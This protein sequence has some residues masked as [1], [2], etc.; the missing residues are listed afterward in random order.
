MRY[1]SFVRINPEFQSSVNLEFDLNRTDKIQGY[2]PTE[3]SVRILGEFLRTFYYNTES[4]GRATVLIGPYGRGKSHLLLVLSA[5]TSLD[6]FNS[7]SVDPDARRIQEELCSKIARVNSEVGALAKAV[8]DSSIRTLPVIINSNSIEINQAFLVA[9]SDSLRRAGLDHLLPETYFDSA[10]SIIEKWEGGFPVAIKTLSEELHKKKTDLDSLKVG[11][12]QFSQHS[13]RLFCD[14]YPVIA[15]GTEF[16]PL[17]NMD[18][19]KLYT[20]V[21]KALKEQ[22]NYSGISIVFDE[23]SKFLEANLDKSKMLNFKIIQDMAEAASRSKETQLHFTCITHKDILDYS[24]SDSFKTVEGRFR[25][26]RVVSSPEQSYELIANA[27][28]KNEA[29]LEYKTQNS[30]KFAVVSSR[31]SVTTVFS[32]LTPEA[33]EDKLINGCFPL[34]PLSAFSLLHVSELV[35]QNERTLFTFL[36]QSGSN[37]LRAFIEKD[38]ETPNWITIDYI[39]DYFE[40]LFRNEVFNT[41]V[42]GIWAKTN[43]A[44]KQVNNKQELAILKA[45]AI[46]NIIRDERLRPIAAHIKSSLLMSDD[47]FER[48][49]KRLIKL[50][51]LSQRDSSEYV[52]LTANGVDVQRSVDNY[53][54]TTLTRINT[55]ETLADAYDPGYVIP[56]E[57]NDKYSMLR[58]F[59]II[60]MEATAFIAYKNANQLLSDYP[61]DGL[62]IY[63]ICREEDLDKKA[64]KK[65]A[66]F[67]EHPQIVVCFSNLAFSQDELL[68]KYK[69]AS[70]LLANCDDQ[71]FTE[72]LEVLKEDLKKRIFTEVQ[73]LFSPSSEHSSYV[74][75]EGVLD[76]GRQSDLNHAIS[77]ICD[78]CYSLTPVVNNEMINKY[79]LSSQIAKAR[80][81]VIAW[82]F[83]HSDDNYIPCMEGSGPEVSIFKSTFK[84]TGLDR[85]SFVTD[86]GMNQTLE[87]ISAFI[88]DSEKKKSNFQPLYQKLTSAPYGIRKGILPLYIA[89]VIRQYKENIVLYFKGKEVELSASSLSNLNEYPENYELLIEAGTAEKNNYLDALQDIFGRYFDKKMPSIN[90]VYSIVKSMQNWMRSL[91]EYTKKYTR[92]LDNGEIQSVDQSIIVVRNELIR[93]EINARELLF[94]TYPSKLC[95]AEGLNECLSIIKN[96]KDLLDGHLSRFRVELTKKITALFIPGYHGGLAKSM[97][98][99]YDKLPESTRT[100]VFDSSTNSLLT[101]ASTIKSYDD[102]QL[103]NDLVNAFVS[104]AIED[105]NDDVSDNFIR[106]ISEAIVKVNDYHGNKKAGVIDGKL[107]ISI[108][109]VSVEKNFTSDAISALGKTAFNNLKSVFEEYNESLEP[110]E[111]LAILVKLIGEIIK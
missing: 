69:A 36:A 48:A 88:R 16:N 22:T 17:T 19:V 5:L 52:L 84:N 81:V 72:E 7:S 47:E 64:H 73:F 71:H 29:F 104:I 14:C 58:C 25:K 92:Y 98:S 15:A 99:W 90:R 12:K 4:Q 26:I 59:K 11:L 54:K 63:L 103:L 38:Y 53:V 111:Q 107:V 45:I 65:I 76:V 109:G 75:Y 87:Q 70:H 3:Q 91:P 85:S 106:N 44:I 34:A 50:H 20:A 101:I 46:I 102:E 49:T 8:V 67:S 62:V 21:A 80:E 51:V 33:Y 9:L 27:I 93:F 32:D 23:F 56:R 74:S 42:H 41:F 82:I 68:K 86:Q 28:A 97:M 55:C 35:G 108:D 77:D 10:L 78:K 105:W 57:Y 94:D 24:S 37:T 30:E 40:D 83:D 60:Y 39:Y 18:V 89:Y 1:S 95:P 100:H 43:S 110:D 66:T 31:A 61:Y 79:S 6:I 13:Y 2:I 96:V